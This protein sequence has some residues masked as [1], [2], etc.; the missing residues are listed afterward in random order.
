[1]C[2][3]NLLCVFVC[4]RESL[5]WVFLA[6]LVYQVYLDL[7]DSQDQREILVSLEDLVDLDDLDLMADLELKVCHHS[8]TDMVFP[9]IRFCLNTEF[10]IF[11]YLFLSIP[12]LYQENKMALSKSTSFRLG[13]KKAFI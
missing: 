11:L 6:L 12:L 4:N 10:F 3:L 9:P 1:M 2:R 8:V 5:V 7:K 13:S